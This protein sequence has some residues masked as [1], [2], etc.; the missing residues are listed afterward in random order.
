M[1][2]AGSSHTRAADPDGVKFNKF[3][4]RYVPHHTRTHQDCLILPQP[5]GY[6]Q[7]NIATEAKNYIKN[8]FGN[9]T[10]ISFPGLDKTKINSNRKVPGGSFKGTP[11]KTALR[12]FKNSR[13]CL[14]ILGSNDWRYLTS[15][16]PEEAVMDFL[17]Q[18][19]SLL[20]YTNFSIVVLT[21]LFPR[22]EM[23]DSNNVIDPKVIKFN[24][25]LLSVKGK[26][27]SN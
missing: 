23:Y 25:F 22:I 21:T 14:L 12:S 6:F 18:I 15:M 19:K 13:I 10:T 11:I 7:Q 16:P 4:G 27:L 2:I 3:S 9:V 1:V 17:H 24:E 8:K 20:N 26:R 5:S